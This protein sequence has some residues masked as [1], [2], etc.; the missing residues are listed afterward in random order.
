MPGGCEPF[1]LA[2]LHRRAHLGHN[3]ARVGPLPAV[4]SRA[5]PADSSTLAPAKLAVPSGTRTHAPRHAAT[6]ARHAAVARARARGCSWVWLTL[7]PMRQVYLRFTRSAGQIFNLPGGAPGV[8][9]EADSAGVRGEGISY[10]SRLVYGVPWVRRTL[11]PMRHVYLRF[12]R[13]AG[14]IF[15]L[16]F[17]TPG[18]RSEASIRC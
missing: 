7:P 16:P 4:T 3:L 10:A 14:Q 11:P 1:V 13:S 6:H 5:P 2:G 8:G 9:L 15:N 17:R 18:L 12:T